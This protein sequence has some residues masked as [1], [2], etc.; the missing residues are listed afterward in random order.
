MDQKIKSFTNDPAGQEEKKKAVIEMVSRGYRVTQEI[1][2]DGAGD[3]ATAT[4]CLSVC[5]LPL[6]PLGLFVSR[7]K[8]RIIVYFEKD[9][10]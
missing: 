2:D 6:A 5:C 4:C 9:D 1:I 3:R 7:G 10:E 8:G